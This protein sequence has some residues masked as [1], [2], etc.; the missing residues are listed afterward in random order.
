[1]SDLADAGVR[2]LLDLYRSGVASP[3]EA[4]AACLERIERLEPSLNAVTTLC[5][6]AAL[7]AAARSAARWARGDPRPLEGVPYGLKDVIDTAGIRTTRG[8]AIFADRVPA[9]DAAVVTALHDAGAILV[10]KLQT[11][12]FALGGPTVEG[13]GWTRNPHDP[14]RIAG[15]SSS[16]PAA[17]V[18]AGMLPLAIGTDTG[19]S[20]RLPAAYC[21]VA[22]LRPTFGR[23][24]RDGVSL[25]T[26]TLDT[27]GPMA[28]EAGDLEPVRA[29]IGP[30]GEGERVAGDL[31]GVVVGVP[32]AWFFE[33]GD[34]GV[35]DAVEQALTTM[36]HLGATVVD[37]DLP[38]APLAGGIGRT[39]VTVEAGSLHEELLELV[40][41]RAYPPD[42]AARLVAARSIPALQY[43]RALR[44]VA[45]FEDDAVNAFA[46]ADVLVTPT[47]VVVAPR[48]ADN[49]PSDGASATAWR[50]VATRT[51]FPFTLAGVP[52]V[53]V[54]AAPS[55]AGLPVGLQIAAPAGRDELCLR[56][57]AIYE[58][59]HRDQ[60]PGIV[61]PLRRAS[62]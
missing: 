8:S 35:L 25:L 1:V 24:A 54:P 9:R 13:F 26:W 18:A 16:G 37:V 43:A 48:H 14:E 50:D 11:F 60:Q 39:V 61:A 22:G 49:A 7:K 17:A 38:H 32:R 5:A 34:D 31:R 41:A 59:A 44:E 3:V 21:G 4:V 28:R 57:A 10:A 51:T 12:A 42:F 36:C 20:I 2:D 23:V 52:A 19:G 47:S 33:Y 53:S 30:P 40:G 62:C 58:R 27:V 29:V 6:E 15:G 46:R 56:V 45:R 55:A